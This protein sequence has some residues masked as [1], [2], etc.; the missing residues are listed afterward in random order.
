MSGPCGGSAVGRRAGAGSG[1]VYPLDDP[2]QA[3]CWCCGS[4]RRSSSEST[5]LVTTPPPGRMCSR[6]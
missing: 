6:G 1:R 5:G 3:G 2:A 4:A